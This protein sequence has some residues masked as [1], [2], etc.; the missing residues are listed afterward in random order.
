MDITTDFRAVSGRR[1]LA[2]SLVRRFRTERGG[3]IGDPNYGELLENH[4]ND[5]MSPADLSA[6]SSAAEAEALKDE[7]V[8]SCSVAA[9]LVDDILYFDI[10]LEDAKGPFALTLSVSDVTVEILTVDQ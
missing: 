5:D 6:A 3:L 10:E 9:R 1:A 8:L 2:E 4:I 7:R